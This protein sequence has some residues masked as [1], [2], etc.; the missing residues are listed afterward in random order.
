MPLFASPNDY[1]IDRPMPAASPRLTVCMPKSTRA[2]IRRLAALQNR[3]Q[4]AI[5]R[6][7][8]VEVEPT[9][10]RI[11]GLIEYAQRENVAA[12]KEWAGYFEA[13]QEEIERFTLG[14]LDEV[15]SILKRPPDPASGARGGGEHPP[16]SN[17][18]VATHL[19]KRK[20]R[21]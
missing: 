6:D 19:R 8:L 7:I 12:F 1:W 17:R 10:Q 13:A 16:L 3:S 20:K 15:D 18:G 4:A 5:V 9:L 11:A 2:T 21:K 14:K